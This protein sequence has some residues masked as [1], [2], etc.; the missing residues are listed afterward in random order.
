M[1]VYLSQVKPEKFAEA[2]EVVK[3]FRAAAI[4]DGWET[5]RTYGSESIDRAMSLDKDGFH[6]STILRENYVS[7][8]V[9]GPDQLSVSFPLPYDFAAM[10]AATRHCQYCGADDVDTTRMGFAGRCC[11]ECRTNPAV[12]NKVEHDGWTK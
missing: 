2:C 9:W 1:E 6:A 11:S 8:S 12:V 10:I 7:I 5:E 4:A 3:A